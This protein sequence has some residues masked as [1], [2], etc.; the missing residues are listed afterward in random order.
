M[1]NRI[2][3]VTGAASRKGIGFGI[4]KCFAEQGAAVVIADLDEQQSRA[5]AKELES[6]GAA[7]AVGTACDITDRT[8]VQNLVEHTVA[9]FGRIDVLVNNAGICPFIDVMEI[10]PEQFK[11]TIEVNLVGAFHCTQLVAA[12]MLERGKGGRIIFITSLSEN[13]T[14]GLQGDYAASKSGL[15]MLMAAFAVRLAPH[16]INCNAV[17]PGFLHTDLTHRFFNKPA[18]EI[19]AGKSIPC[20]RLC[21]PQD[22]GHAV[23]FLAS[24]GA[25]HINGITLRVD[26]GFSAKG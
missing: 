24:K 26:G 2:V 4:G 5:A 17:A 1:E 18:I 6:A 20:G 14:N 12:N 19:D 9:Q 10:S 11:R 25:E 22:I 13:I 16:G 8:Q 21:T 7:E 15:R 23:L 3:I